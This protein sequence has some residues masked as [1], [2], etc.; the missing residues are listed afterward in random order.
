MD[1]GFASADRKSTVMIKSVPSFVPVSGLMLIC[2]SCQG[3][4]GEIDAD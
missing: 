3:K 1:F 2:E 4:R